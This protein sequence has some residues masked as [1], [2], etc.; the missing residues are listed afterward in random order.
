[1]GVHLFYLCCCL[2]FYFLLKLFYQKSELYFRTLKRRSFKKCTFCIQL[3]P[4]LIFLW[5]PKLKLLCFC[6]IFVTLSHWSTKMRRS[7]ASVT[8]VFSKFN[9]IF[10]GIISRHGKALL[11]ELLAFYNIG[12]VLQIFTGLVDIKLTLPVP[13]PDKE[14]KLT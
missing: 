13:I 11:Y 9:I 6:I 3:L 14:K 7:S 4:G 10:T 2:C 12:R 1:M 8:C 5:Y